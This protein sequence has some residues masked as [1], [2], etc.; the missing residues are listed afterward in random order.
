MKLFP[1]DIDERLEFNKIRHLLSECCLSAMGREATAAMQP[2]TDEATIVRSLTQT[3]ELKNIEATGTYFPAQDYFDIREELNHLRVNEYVLR[4]S[5]MLRLSVFLGTISSIFQFIEKHQ[6]SIPSLSDLLEDA[7]YDKSVK[8]K[9]EEIIDDKGVVRSDASEELVRIR[10]SMIKQQQE[11]EKSFRRVAQQLR[12]KGYLADP[13]ES[14][15]NGRRVLAILAEYKR[16]VKGIIHDESDSGKT[17]FIEPDETVILNNELFELEREESR[18]IYRILKEL[19]AELRLDLSSFQ[20]YFA[21]LG[22]A[23]LLRAKVRLSNMLDAAAPHISPDPSILLIRARHPLLYLINHKQGKAIVPFTAHLNDEQQIILVSGPNA[24]GKSVA[25]KSFGLMQWMF[26]CGLHIPADAGSSLGIFER[27]MADVG[28]SQSLEDE[29]STYSSRL[30]N[31]RCFVEQANRKTLFLIDEFGTGTDPVFGGAIAEAL[32]REM[33]WL[34]ARGVVNTHYGNLKIFADK[35]KNIVNAAMIFDEE[36]LSPTY[37]LKV[38]SPGSSYTFVI[39]EKNNLPQKIVN[40]AKQLVGKQNVKYED[41]LFSLETERKGLMQEQQ[42]MLAEH[43][44]LKDLMRK[45]ELQQKEID[46]QRKKLKYDQLLLQKDKLQAKE[47]ALQD[48]L[49]EIRQNQ[50]QEDAAKEALK[51]VNEQRSTI[52]KHVDDSVKSIRTPTDPGVFKVGLAVRMIGSKEIGHIEQLSK[53]K[54]VVIFEHMKS[55]LPLDQLEPVDK[56]TVDKQ[57]SPRAKHDIIKEDNAPQLD[58]RGMMKEEA[59]PL[60][61]QFIDRAIIYG[62]PELRILHG[63]GSGALRQ[64]VTSYVKGFKEVSEVYHPAREFGGDGITIIKF[65]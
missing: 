35:N 54:A 4:E 16:V 44:K 12:S 7:V 2:S 9:I 21:L 34:K 57:L 52:D 45:V 62:R 14:V 53:G 64:L 17:S 56:K 26:Q 15:R 48:F 39:A 5:E 55:T 49:K 22:R 38:G 36:H 24:G 30:R 58:L 37:Q 65:K 59:Y 1:A 43:K 3:T 41:L 27:M 33:L 13:G 11:L 50:K 63:K 10:R 19:S 31:M 40:Y 61:E 8:K 42:E 18:E 32:L 46:F 25:M 20:S 60:L 6:E 51:K 47:D 23:D 29:L 28:D